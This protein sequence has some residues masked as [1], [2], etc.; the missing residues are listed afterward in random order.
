MRRPDRARPRGG[1]SLLEVICAL[2]VLMLGCTIV[3]SALTGAGRLIE[4]RAE[5]TVEFDIAVELL[6]CVE[7]GAPPP[8]AAEP[9][10][11]GDGASGALERPEG[12][13]RYSIA[14]GAAKDVDG[15][16]MLVATVA[17]DDG[18]QRVGAVVGRLVPPI[19]GEEAAR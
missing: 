2:I 5:A 7:V 17:R 3:S 1:F 12:R 9:L 16:E 4:I 18:T 13:F 15:M 6:D 8:G 14:R 11:D 19:G 10:G